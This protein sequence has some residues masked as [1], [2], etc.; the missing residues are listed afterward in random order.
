MDRPAAYA[1]MRR[2]ITSGG[3][4]LIGFHVS[5]LGEEPGEIMH[6]EQWW[7]EH[8]DLDTYYIDPAEVTAGLTAAGFEIMAR[9]DRAPWPGAEHQSRRCY[10]LCRRP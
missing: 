3:W 2:A 5:R 6:I 9:T 1:E 8:V 4:L 10:L 7:G